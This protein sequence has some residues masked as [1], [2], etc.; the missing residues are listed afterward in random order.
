[1]K[2][3]GIVRRTRERILGPLL[4]C[5]RKINVVMF[6]IGRSGSTVLSDL[7]GQH[8]RVFWDGQIYERLFEQL[9][10]SSTRVAPGSVA[11]HNAITALQFR[12]R[13]AGERVYGFEVKFF[14]L[15]C[16]GIDLKEYV[17][18]LRALGFTHFVILERR[19][20][21]RK[22]L[23]SVVA[24]RVGHVSPDCGIEATAC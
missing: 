8:S 5:F 22:I 3:K 14:H 11:R 19:N 10:A 7:L 12:M 13:A 15:R 23:S 24:H 21:L 20:Y 18:H 1:M 2:G 4:S 17:A 9:E 6:H 16:F